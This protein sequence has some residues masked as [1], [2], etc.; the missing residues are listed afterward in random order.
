MPATFMLT[1]D[2]EGRWGVADHLTERDR[3]SL[4]D[5]G[6]REAYASILALLDE[7]G[8]AATFAF[9]GAFSQSPAEFGRLRPI[10]EDFRGFAPDYVGVALRDLDAGGGAGWHGDELVHLVGSARAGHE[11][12]LHGVTHVPWTQLDDRGVD[13]E[14]VLFR[15][16]AGPVRASRTFVY[17]RN[18]VAHA[19]RLAEHGFEG[20]RLAPPP[21]SR[22]RSLLAEFNMFEAPEQPTNADGL[23]PIP[24]GFFLNWRSGPRRLVPPSLTRLRARRLL[25]AATEA[26]GIVHYWLHPENIATAPSTLDLLRMLVRDVAEAREAGHCEVLTQLDYCRSPLQPA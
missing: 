19:D 17:P 12:A 26:N 4:T 14:M 8:I 24:A 18:L 10:L 13:A 20:Y 22:A 6:L 7:C 5:K 25:D 2:C 11:V 9:V 1:F 3:A 16:L 15:S 23:R 21:R